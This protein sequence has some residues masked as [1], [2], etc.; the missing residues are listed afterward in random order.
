MARWSSHTIGGPLLFLG[1]HLFQSVLGTTVIPLC[2]TN[3]TDNCTTALV[4]TQHSPRVAQVEITSCRSEMQNYCFNGQ[5][6]YLV[7]LNAHHCRCHKGYFGDRCSHS[8]LDSKLVIQPLSNEYLALTIILV[9]LFFIAILVA[10][11]YFYRW[12]QNKKGRLAASRNY[13]EVATETKK[14]NKLLHV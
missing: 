7:S 6:I 4:R 10:S 13:R 11:Y 9:M 2:G 3:E 12:Y 14:D 8:T 5:C 1:F